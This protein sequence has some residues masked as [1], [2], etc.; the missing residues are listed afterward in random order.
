VQALVAAGMLIQRLVHGL[1]LSGLSTV[2]MIARQRCHVHHASATH[3]AAR[4]NLAN[5][6]RFGRLAVVRRGR[7]GDQACEALAL[8]T[9]W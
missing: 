2:K 6:C 4:G 8:I 5:G 3:D 7:I 9:I 1:G